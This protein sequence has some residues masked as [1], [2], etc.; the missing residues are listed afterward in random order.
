ML[1]E[2]VLIDFLYHI[3]SMEYKVWVWMIL[4]QVPSWRGHASPPYASDAEVA[5]LLTITLA[6]SPFP[7][8]KYSRLFSLNHSS[9]PKWSSVGRALQ[10]SRRDNC[11]RKL[12]MDL[13]SNFSLE[14]SFY[15]AFSLLLFYLWETVQTPLLC[16]LAVFVLNRLVCPSFI[17]KRSKENGGGSCYNPWR[18]YFLYPCDSEVCL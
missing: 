2:W 18:C 5:F 14:T 3:N 6:P 4:F 1:T 8:Y 15:L 16:N 11:R 10:N 13:I 7:T 9:V 17:W 12:P